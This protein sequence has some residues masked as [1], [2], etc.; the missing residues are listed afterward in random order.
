LGGARADWFA[1]GYHEVQLSSEHNRLK[2]FC[3]QH[4]RRLMAL[5]LVLMVVLKKPVL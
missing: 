4:P 3:A 1:S 5:R 2:I